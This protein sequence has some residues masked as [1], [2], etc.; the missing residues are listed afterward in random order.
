MTTRGGPRPSTSSDNSFTEGMYDSTRSASSRAPS[1]HPLLRETTGGSLRALLRALST[2]NL[3][4]RI[5]AVVLWWPN[6]RI[7]R[8][9]ARYNNRNGGLLS[10]GMAL[11]TLLSLTAALT[12]G[13]TVFMSILGGSKEL[14][15]AVFTN[16]DQALPNLLAT[17]S[18]PDG[19]V[20]PDSLIYSSSLSW[21]GG[22]SFAV[23]I[24]VGINVVGQMGSSIRAMFAVTAIPDSYLRT[25]LRNIL[26]ALGIGVSFLLAAALTVVTDIAGEAI[27]DAIGWSGTGPR[28][29]ATAM[30]YTVQVL[31]YAAAT[32]L[33]IRLVAGVRVPRRELLWGLA[34]TG[35]FSLVLRIIGTSAAVSVK[36]PLLTTATALVT[37]VLWLNLQVRLVLT[38]CAW[39]ANP[40]RL[41]LVTNPD[42]VHF[43]ECPNYV[44]VSAPHT[45]VWP[46]N[47]ASGELVPKSSGV[48]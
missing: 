5:N 29:A 22:I 30:S 36:G 3:L 35:A 19:L 25:L 17:P 8:T 41:R 37:L 6:T 38:M 11:T 28:L 43:T 45:L 12:A 48:N 32:W 9:L 15:A 46:H 33:L 47:A 26:G 27:F 16:L 7:A 24:W 1:A 21:T 42:A 14:R 18:N 34:A 2:G 4:T 44:T 10:T 13:L 40:P 20:N 23:A 31:V 39:M